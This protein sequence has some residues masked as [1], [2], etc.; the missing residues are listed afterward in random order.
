MRGAVNLSIDLI[1]KVFYARPACGTGLCGA[2]G[3]G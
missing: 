1:N 2:Y 3:A